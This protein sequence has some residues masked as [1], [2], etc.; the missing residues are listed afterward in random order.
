MAAASA[1]GVTECSNWAE[2]RC[3]PVEDAMT[4]AHTRRRN[5]TLTK[6]LPDLCR[7]CCV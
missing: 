2:C 5:L 7:G 4:L 6:A 3:M 1:L